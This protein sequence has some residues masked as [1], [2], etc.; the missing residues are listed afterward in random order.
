MIGSSVKD[1]GSFCQKPLE[2]ILYK[3]SR[4]P[5]CSVHCSVL[6]FYLYSVADKLNEIDIL[7]TLSSANALRNASVLSGPSDSGTIV[8][9][10][11]H[12]TL[13]H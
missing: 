4:Q 5:V 9:S 3:D 2:A 7:G 12:P 6:L 10:T 1:F 8:P 13:L 11:H